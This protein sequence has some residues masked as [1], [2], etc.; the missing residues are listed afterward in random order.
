V[1]DSLMNDKEIQDAA[2]IAIQDPKREEL[3]ADS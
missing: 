2:A 1:H 3:T